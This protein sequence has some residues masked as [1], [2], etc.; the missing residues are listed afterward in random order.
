[1]V[2]TCR[3]DQPYV[4]F[5]GGCP[6]VNYSDKITISVIQGENSHVCFDFTSKIIDFFT[7][8]KPFVEKQAINPTQTPTSALSPQQTTTVT[9]DNPQALLVLLEEEFVAIDLVSEGWPQYRLPYLYSVHSSAVICTHY[10][11]GVSSSFYDRLK[12]YGELAQ[13]SS[14]FYSSKDW[15]VTAVS[16]SLN[17]SP[18]KATSANTPAKDLL[19]TG[20]EDGSVRFWDVT[21][22]SMT[23][24]YRL[25]T[26]DYFQTDSTPVDESNSNERNN[27]PNSMSSAVS[28]DNWP[29]FRKVGTFDP[30]SDDPKLG[31]QKIFLCPQRHVLVVAGTAGQVLI[32][33][34]CEQSK[35]LSFNAIQAHKINIIGVSPEVESHFVWKGHEPLALRGRLG[36]LFSED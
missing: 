26:S 13:D 35:E 25:R 21:Q 18:I 20:H 22:M 24:I 30:Y 15:P 1:M 19:L 17:S 9:Y 32:M 4:I 12:Q 2:K 16:Q 28:A 31:I 33:N 7:I 29:P 14:E 8:D 23:L 36:K 6:R 27:N 3:A 11:N 34:I 10:V 5:S